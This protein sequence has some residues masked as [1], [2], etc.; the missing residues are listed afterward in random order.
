MLEGL[1]SRYEV[2]TH[3]GGAPRFARRGAMGQILLVADRHL[4]MREVLFKT[5]HPDHLHDLRD[6]RL[7]LRESHLLLQIQCDYVVR[8]YD[9]GFF[10]VPDVGP[11]GYFTMEYL[12][13]QTLLE[14]LDSGIPS[15]GEALRWM[16]DA[17]RALVALGDVRSPAKPG[18]PELRGIVH[19]DL[20]PENLMLVDDTGGGGAGAPRDG[21]AAA[22][23]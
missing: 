8:I 13:G 23:G 4:G 20:K 17:A 5:L 9:A 7:F 3:D 6:R 1:P 2:V 16:E 14:R 21:A 19:R 18:Q 12:H 15:V 22:G 11:V 10:E